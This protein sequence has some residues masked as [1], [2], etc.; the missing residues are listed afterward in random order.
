MEIR[1]KI[2]AGIVVAM[3]THDGSQIDDTCGRVVAISTS[4]P[5]P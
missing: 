3:K 2:H 5:A 4:V 1:G